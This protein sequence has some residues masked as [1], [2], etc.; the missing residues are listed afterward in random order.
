[1]AI[2]EARAQNQ[3]STNRFL[4][5]VIDMLG[6]ITLEEACE[7]PDRADK[8][9]E[10]AALY[11]APHDLD[12]Y[13]RQIKSITDERVAISDKHGIGYT[14]VSLTVP[15]IQGISDQGEA[16]KEA[17]RCNEYIYN[18]IKDHRDRLGAFAALSMHDPVQAG[19]ELRRCVKEYGFHGA[20]INDI[21]HAGKDGET[22]LFYDQPKYDAFWNV[23]QELDV[24]VYIHP[25]A[26]VGQRFRKLYAERKYLVGPPLSF[27]N[28]VSLHLLG[29]ISN[30][31]FDRFPNLK[32]IVGHLGEHIPFDFWRTNHWLVDVEQPLALKAGDTICK[33]DLYYYFKRNIWLTTSG[34]FST[35]TLKY[36]N[37]YLG[38]SRL[39]FSV[40][41]PY[42]TIEMGCGWW[43][44]DADAIKEALGGEQA[45][46]DVGRENAKKL[47]KLGTYHDSNA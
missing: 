38:P 8:S 25:A 12:R 18:A 27:A 2:F 32:I 29:I 3:D 35:P 46:L 23:V 24:P 19:E 11:I 5:K 28:A 39:L 30:G 33:N 21:Q 1:L 40:D 16:E 26:P 34:H 41:Y 9:R 17:S 10:Q 15:G 42:E 20:L 47:L 22:F 4:I 6:K 45:Y 36:V 43:D 13:L 31:V 7:L 14:V 44:G 37:D